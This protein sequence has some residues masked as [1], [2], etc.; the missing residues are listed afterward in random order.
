LIFTWDI[1]VPANTLE[2]APASDTLKLSAGVI[3]HI[4]IKFPAGCHGMVGV[5]L[6][7]QEAQILPVPRGE[8]VTGDDETCESDYHIEFT[9]ER[10]EME[11]EG[12]S[13]DTD[14]DHTISVRITMLPSWVAAPYMVLVDLVKIF[15]RL[16]GIE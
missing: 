2:S 14:Y 3:T 4:G 11:F 10:Q 7:I 16:L 6:K 5:R 12:I 15:K 8:W 9:R 13:P 1:I